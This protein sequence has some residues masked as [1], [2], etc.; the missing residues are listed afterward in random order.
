M[1]ANLL[2]VLLL[3][4][5]LA[6]VAGPPAVLPP[7][8]PSVSAAKASMDGPAFEANVEPEGERPDGVSRRVFPKCVSTYPH[9]TQAPETSPTRLAP[10]S[11]DRQQRTIVSYGSRAPPAS[12]QF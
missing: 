6:L 10:G 4:P 8:S 12:W 1:V 9:V 2:V 7:A 5:W 3:A 11:E